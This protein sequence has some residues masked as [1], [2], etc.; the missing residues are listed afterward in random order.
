MNTEDKVSP[1]NLSGS[2]IVTI[3]NKCPCCGGEDFYYNGSYFEDDE[4]GYEELK[5]NDCGSYWKIVYKLE[6]QQIIVCTD[7]F[8]T[9][10][11]WLAKSRD[12]KIDSIL[13]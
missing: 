2:E 7:N 9:Y 4:M 10:E 8:N 3:T 1:D 12:E 13:N 11:K 6:L 5:C